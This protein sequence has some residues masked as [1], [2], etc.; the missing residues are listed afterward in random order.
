LNRDRDNG[1][2]NFVLI[3]LLSPRHIAQ[4]RFY[5]NLRD[6]HGAVAGCLW[7]VNIEDS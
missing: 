2:R 7:K 5:P 4:F 3:R 1:I 6:D